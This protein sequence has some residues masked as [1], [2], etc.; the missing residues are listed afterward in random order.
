MNVKACLMEKGLFPL[1]FNTTQ[2]RHLNTPES[3]VERELWR[4]SPREWRMALDIQHSSSCGFPGQ[5]WGRQVEQG[6]SAE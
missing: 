1:S 5:R 6:H 4:D 2:R 3:K